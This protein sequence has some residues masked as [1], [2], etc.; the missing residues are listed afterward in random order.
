[1]A[2]KALK[3]YI[4]RRYERWLD[5]SRFHCSLTGMQGEETDVLN[6]VL[7]MLLEKPSEFVDRLLNAKKG[8]YTELDFYILQMIKLNST[9]DT[10][11]YRHK[12]KAIPT[13]QNVDFARLDILDDDDEIDEHD[14]SEY[15]CKR[16]QDIRDILENLGVTD[17]AKKVF[18]WKFF[19]GESFSDWPGPENNKELSQIYRSV[20]RTIEDKIKGNIL[21]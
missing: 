10:S 11:P 3:E 19:D 21:F 1:M 7:A 13:D 2:S 5:Y 6:E 14:G 15:I 20:M 17:L 4:N 16:M 8:R 9:S 12:Y 18:I